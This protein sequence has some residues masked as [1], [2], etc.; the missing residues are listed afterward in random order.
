MA[1]RNAGH[2]KYTD[3]HAMV[4]LGLALFLCGCGGGHTPDAQ[5]E[6]LFDKHRAEFEELLTMARADAPQVLS[7]TPR[8]IVTQKRIIN[9]AEHDYVR[10]EIPLSDARLDRY[11]KLLSRLHLLGGVLGGNRSVE[12]EVDPPSLMNGDSSKG[13]VYSE[14]PCS[15][16]LDDL[17]S[18]EAEGRDRSS[19]GFMVYKRLRPH[20]YIYLFISG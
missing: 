18:Y 8:G 10:A 12:F 3:A 4:W 16:V 2:V 1:I 15:R 6:K 14:E 20:W 5:I 13:I 9:L 17:D 7:V 19:S 11:R